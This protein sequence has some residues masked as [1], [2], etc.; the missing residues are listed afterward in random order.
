MLTRASDG[1]A[2]SYGAARPRVLRLAPLGVAMRLE[3]RGGS[4]AVDLAC[5]GWAGEPGGP[6]PALRLSLDVDPALRGSGP[7]AVEVAGRRLALRGPGLCGGACADRGV[8]W[9]RLSADWQHDPERLRAEALD[10]LVLFLVARHG[11]TP[12]HAAAIERGGL[13]IVLAGPSGAGKS[14]LALAADR[15]GWDVLAEDT[16]YVQEAPQPALWGSPGPAH[17]LPGEASPA[18]GAIR[19]RNGTLK[20]A[21]ALRSQPESAP[22]ARQATL[23][24]L[25][26]GDAAGL[27]PLTPAEALRALPPPEPGF[28]LLAPAIARASALLASRGAW[29]LTLSADPAEALALLASRLPGLRRSAWASGRR[30]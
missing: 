6:G 25:A 19:W 8:A 3:A 22:V 11:R 4:A 26:R 24:V 17:V 18:P 2:P 28:D 20:H 10:P 1:A 15:A 16:V 23:C 9:C 21:V 29:R 13:A 7:P 12:I 5:R 27:E 14:T 30:D